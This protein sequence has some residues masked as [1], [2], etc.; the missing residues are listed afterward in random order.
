MGHL[1]RTCSIYTGSY[2]DLVYR[3]GLEAAGMVKE[4]RKDEGDSNG[5]SG[6]RVS[7]VLG[8]ATGRSPCLERGGW[9]WVYISITCQLA[10]TLTTTAGTDYELTFTAGQIKRVLDLAK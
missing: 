3:L 10:K 7:A 9:S 5:Y 4:V 2:V 6:G 8:R 1:H